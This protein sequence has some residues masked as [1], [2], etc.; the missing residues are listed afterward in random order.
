MFVIFRTSRW[1]STQEK[2]LHILNVETGL[3]HIQVAMHREIFS[4]QLS[5]VL[6]LKT[7]KKRA[8]MNLSFKCNI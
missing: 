1:T 8:H 7:S 4:V 6:R 2:S 3:T 5:F